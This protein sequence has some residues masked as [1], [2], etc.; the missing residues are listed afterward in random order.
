MWDRTFR[1]MFHLEFLCMMGRK[2]I[3]GGTILTNYI[4]PFVEKIILFPLYC[5][6]IF[7]ESQLTHIC[8][9]LSGLSILFCYLHSCLLP[10]QHCFD[11]YNFISLQLFLFQNCFVISRSFEFPYKFRISLLIF[12]KKPDE[13]WIGIILN[14]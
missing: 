13:I 4:V 5:P 12:I 9:F 14:Q 7:V 1:V 8:V 2:F 11:Y 6:G 3:L 10:I